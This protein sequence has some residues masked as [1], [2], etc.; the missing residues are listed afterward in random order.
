MNPQPNIALVHDWLTGMRGGEKVLEV[1]CELY[2]DATLFTLL[3]NKGAMSK[4]I[5]QMKIKT[6]FVDKLPLKNESYRN[7]LPLFPS[8]IESFDFKGFDLI[9][10]TSHC[11]AKGAIPSTDALHICYCHTPMRYIWEM[12]DEY[13]GKGRAGFM[14]R[15]AMSYIAP[16]LREWD[17][18]TSTRVHYFIANS[19]NVAD[20]I[21]RYYNRTADIIHA[22]VDASLFK[23]SEKDD[24]Y[25]LI[26]SALVP[27]KRVDLAIEVFNKLGN[28]LVIVGKGPEAEKLKALASKNIE[29]LGWQSDEELAK[30]YAGCRALIFPGVEDFGIVPLEAMA[31]GKPVVAFAQGGA[32]ETVVEEGDH[33]TGIF[34]YEQTVPALTDAIT[35][36]GGLKLN[37]Q[38]IRT[39]AEQFDRMKFK[40][41]LSEYI[42]GKVESTLVGKILAA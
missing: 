17:V 31:C 22:P 4:T 27:Y 1:L 18:R 9:I 13:F 32:L 37:P 23:L 21:Q 5:E 39:H 8:A 29:F 26:V 15:A 28:K 12:Y 40:G 41:K 34:F 36:L 30:L 10:S 35:S 24:G 11:V 25:Y 14:T 42:A 16:R 33:R 19:K 20:R 7:Y 38:A 2:P 6:S 3:H